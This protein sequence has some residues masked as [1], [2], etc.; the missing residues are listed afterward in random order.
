MLAIKQLARQAWHQFCWHPITGPAFPMAAL[1]GLVTWVSSAV[2]LP[3][4]LGDRHETITDVDC[5]DFADQTQAQV[6]YEAQGAE[7]PYLIEYDRDG[8]VCEALASSIDHT[9]ISPRM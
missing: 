7:D 2:G 5:M 9:S 8:R 6:F 1:I 3:T 4:D